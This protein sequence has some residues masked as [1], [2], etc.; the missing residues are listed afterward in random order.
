MNNSEEVAELLG[1]IM[2]VGGPKE[3]GDL[4]I[5]PDCIEGNVATITLEGKEKLILRGKYVEN[6][7]CTKE[8]LITQLAEQ[9]T[10]IEQVLSEFKDEDYEEYYSDIRYHWQSIDYIKAEIKEALEL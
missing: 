3:Y 5:H 7:F 10:F 9:L 8:A 6:V 1:L 2:V 4:Y